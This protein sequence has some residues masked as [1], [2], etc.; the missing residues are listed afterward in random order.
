MKSFEAQGFNK[1]EALKQTGSDVSL[2]ML[3][4]ATASWKKAGSPLSNKALETFM[5]NYLL[6][7]K[8]VGAYIV[9]EPSSDDTRTRPYSVINE[10]TKG[11]RKTETFYQ[12]KEADFK[13][14]TKTSTNEAGEEVVEKIVTVL[15]TGAVV[16]KAQKALMITTLLDAQKKSEAMS[17]LKD[18][19]SSDRKNFVIEIGKEVTSGQKY[20]AYGLYTPSSNAKIGKFIFFFEN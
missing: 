3:R 12:I 17:L 15:S 13:V 10:A 18:R 4:N 11:K 9:V 20:A 2:D 14:K 6:E 19:I 16:D 1:V 5:K 7:K 8:A